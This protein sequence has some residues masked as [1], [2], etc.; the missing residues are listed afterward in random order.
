MA[1]PLPWRIA[2]G[3][4]INVWIINESTTFLYQELQTPG[5]PASIAIERWDHGNVPINPVTGEEVGETDPHQPGDTSNG[6]DKL[7]DREGLV[8]ENCLTGTRIT[9]YTLGC[10]SF[11]ASGLSLP[12]ML[13]YRSGTTTPARCWSTVT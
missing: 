9:K 2:Q 1:K 6:D 4:D 13:P 7:I 5:T 3:D 8:V 10:D 12:A 11:A